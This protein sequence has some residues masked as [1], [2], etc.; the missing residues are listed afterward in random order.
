MFSE[1]DLLDIHFGIHGDAR[2]I[3]T[4]FGYVPIENRPVKY[5]GVVRCVSNLF[6]M[7]CTTGLLSWA[8]I[9]FGVSDFIEKYQQ[10]FV[11]TTYPPAD[12]N[13]FRLL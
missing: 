2:A 1:D 9:L 6:K 5:G 3:Q 13:I 8:I 11:N 12:I 7:F 4:R 10:I